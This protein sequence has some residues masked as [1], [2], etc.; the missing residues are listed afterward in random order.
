MK[1]VPITAIAGM[2]QKGSDETCSLWHGL[3]HWPK[4]R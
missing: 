3:R 1:N 4:R 2:D